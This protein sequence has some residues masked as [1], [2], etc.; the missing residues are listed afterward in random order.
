MK[1]YRRSY[2]GE[3]AVGGGRVGRA[4]LQGITI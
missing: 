3:G 4:N 1:F 2:G